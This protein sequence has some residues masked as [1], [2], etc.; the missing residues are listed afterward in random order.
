M[1]WIRNI[2]PHLQ[3]ADPPL[4]LNKVEREKKSHRVIQAIS[5]CEKK[6]KGNQMLNLAAQRQTVGGVR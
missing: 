5:A 1:D 2:V 3:D 6:R 4:R